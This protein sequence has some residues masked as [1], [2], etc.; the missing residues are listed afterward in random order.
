MTPSRLLA[1]SVL[2]RAWRERAV[3]VGLGRVEAQ[4]LVVGGR[5]VDELERRQRRA[6]ALAADHEL[7]HRPAAGRGDAG[8][9]LARRR[10]G[11]VVDGDE[12]RV[13]V[14]ELLLQRLGRRARDEQLALVAADLPADLVL[15]A[16][17]V[18]VLVGQE[19]GRERGVRPGRGPGVRRLR[20]PG[21]AARRRGGCHLSP[22]RA[23]ALP[24]TRVGCHSSAPARRQHPRGLPLV[25]RFLGRGLG[26]GGLPLV[27]L[28][29]ARRLAFRGLPGKLA[30]AAGIAHRWVPFRCAAT[31]VPS[32][33]R[34]CRSTGAEPPKRSVIAGIGATR[35]SGRTW[36]A[37]RGFPQSRRPAARSGSSRLAGAYSPARR[38]RRHCVEPAI[39][40]GF[41]LAASRCRSRSGFLA[42]LPGGIHKEI[43]CVTTRSCS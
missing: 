21:R 38:Q 22:A 9:E 41:S 20:G 11:D 24:W 17:E 14:V 29:S 32:A 39:L 19:L 34:R 13:E 37:R 28:R 15:L 1:S 7:L 40:I 26:A 8:E 10:G 18:V 6:V 43:R 3:G 25:D 4:R 36:R 5:Q 35:P 42:R 30:A 16:G 23:G 27:A 2:A 33:P 31:D 12:F